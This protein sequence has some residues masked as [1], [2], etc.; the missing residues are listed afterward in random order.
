MADMKK[1][2]R[3][4]NQKKMRC[5]LGHEFDRVTGRGKRVCTTCEI[6]YNHEYYLRVKDL[7]TAPAN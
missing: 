6:V 1:K 5:P 4:W 2:G 3:Q 7:D